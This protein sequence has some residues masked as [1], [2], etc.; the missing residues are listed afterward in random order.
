MKTEADY[1]HILRN[2]IMALRAKLETCP[3][4]GEITF[5]YGQDYY[6]EEVRSIGL[7]MIREGLYQE[8]EKL[9]LDYTREH[10]PDEAET[11]TRWI[12][13]MMRY[14]HVIT[15][16]LIDNL[17]AEGYTA[18]QSNTDLPYENALFFPVQSTGQANY[19]QKGSEIQT[20]VPLD[21]LI[22]IK[23]PEGLLY[24][25]SNAQTY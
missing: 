10:Y 12:G 8:G 21:M 14:L 23:K 22:E 11:E 5:S 19:F 24:F 13:K 20:Q 25:R 9:I 7:R 1:L 4:A 16:A 3:H 17:K 2:R 18:L 15:D 6:Q